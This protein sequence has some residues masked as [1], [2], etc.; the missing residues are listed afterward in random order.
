MQCRAQSVIDGERFCAIAFGFERSHQ[1]AVAVLPER[2]DLDQG[3]PRAK[4]GVELRAAEPH[5]RLRDALERSDSHGLEVSPSFGDPRCVFAGEKDA[6]RRVQ[7]DP[8]GRPGVAPRASAHRGLGAVY[9]LVGALDVDQRIGRQDDVRL[10][11]AGERDEPAQLGEE[12]AQSSVGAGR[13]LGRPERIH[14]LGAGRRSEP[15]RDEVG[16]QKPAL[17]PGE[18]R[19]DPLAVKPRDQAAAKLDPRRQGF[20]KLTA[21]AEL[22]NHGMAKLLIQVTRGPEDPTR[23]ALA[24]LVGRAAAEQGHDV[25]LFLAGDGVQLLRPPVLDSLVGLGTGS[26]RDS[27]DA[28]R[29]AG[30]AFYVS[31]MSSKARG[32]EPDGIAEPAVPAKL[33]ELT[34]EHDRVLIY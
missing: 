10:R 4:G 3:V 33:V 15:V 9:R 1:E 30:A 18:A 6:R 20:A 11:P 8:G 13:R 7:C 2:S 32:F 28:L 34:L 29:A 26:L 19:L 12:G 25:S 14:Q 22:H 27:Y 21:S 23:A 24:F 16:E 31:A 17:A 5:C